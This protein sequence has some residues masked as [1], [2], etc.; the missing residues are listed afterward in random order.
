MLYNDSTEPM[1][2]HLNNLRLFALCKLACRRPASWR[3]GGK[4]GQHRAPYFLTGR[5]QVG[6]DLVTDSATENIPP[7]SDRG[8]GEKVG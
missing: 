5:Y 3:E 4:S 1:E 8:K 7:R 6:D 2:S